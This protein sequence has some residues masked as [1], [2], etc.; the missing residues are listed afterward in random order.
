ML[1]VVITAMVFK[2]LLV[3]TTRRSSSY[4]WREEPKSMPKTVIKFGPKV[5]G[6]K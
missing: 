6:T 1:E 2:Q 3:K 5:C 4:F